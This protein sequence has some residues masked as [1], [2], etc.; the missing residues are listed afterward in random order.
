MRAVVMLSLVM[1]SQMIFS[2]NSFSLK[3]SRRASCV[4][5]LRRSLGANSG[6]EFSMEDLTSLKSLEDAKHIVQGGGIFKIHALG[7]AAFGSAL[8]LFPD[9][10]GGGPVTSFAYQQWAVFILAVSYITNKAGDLDEKAQELLATAYFVMCT[11]EALLY[12]RELLTTI[13]RIPFTFYVIDVSSLL[14]FGGLAAGYFFSGLTSFSSAE[15]A[16]D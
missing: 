16:G 6:T 7:A 15:A 12:I 5:G 2:S 10:I 11:T 8:L 3:S 13:G 14:V 1:V 4:H 9:A